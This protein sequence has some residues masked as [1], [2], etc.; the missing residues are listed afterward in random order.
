MINQI[1]CLQCQTEIL[2]PR[3]YKNKV[4]QKYCTPKCRI[5]YHNELKRQ[6]IQK[7]EELKKELGE[8]KNQGKEKEFINV[9][10]GLLKEFQ[11]LK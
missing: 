8:L 9:L 6:A 11:F 3:E 7:Q 10:I 4:V 5:N 1:L 2:N